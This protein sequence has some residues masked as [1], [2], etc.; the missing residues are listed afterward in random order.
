MKTYKEY[1][2]WESIKK[3]KKGLYTLIHK[4]KSYNIEFFSNKWHVEPFEDDS[5]FINIRGLV[6][7]NTKKEAI[8]FIIDTT[9]KDI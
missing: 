4:G 6:N 8:Q 9:K 5:R 3:V 2:L 1:F 7:F